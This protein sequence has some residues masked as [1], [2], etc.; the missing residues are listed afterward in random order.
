[1][2]HFLNALQNGV[3]INVAPAPNMGF[4]GGLKSSMGTHIFIADIDSEKKN[5]TL[6][7][8][9][10]IRKKGFIKYCKRLKKFKHTLPIKK[11]V[12]NK[13]ATSQFPSGSTS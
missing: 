11:N 13:K 8:G 5:V 3:Q 7:N 6:Y 10:E 12:P 4:G 1:M 2:Q 9:E